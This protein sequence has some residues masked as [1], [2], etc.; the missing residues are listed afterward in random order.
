MELVDGQTLDALMARERLAIP[1][2]LTLALPTDALVAAHQ[3]GITHRDLKPGNVIVTD[4]GRLKV[5]DFGLAKA[6]NAP[7]RDGGPHAA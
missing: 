7:A 6:V 4:D 5:L 2:F 1:R 3:R